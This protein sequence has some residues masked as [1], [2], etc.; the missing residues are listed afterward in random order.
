MRSGSQHSRSAGALCINAG[1]ACRARF[2]TRQERP[3][4]RS[5][6]HGAFD[7]V[8]SSLPTPDGACWLFF[9]SCHVRSGTGARQVMAAN[10][11]ADRLRAAGCLTHRKT[12]LTLTVC[13]CCCSSCLPHR[14][15]RR[16]CREHVNGMRICRRGKLLQSVINAG[17][18]A[19]AFD[20]G[21]SMI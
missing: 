19:H 6:T 16:W 18:P 12:G 20:V 8:P 7:A 15:G 1:C 21:P 9:G 17:L 3:V 11:A 4:C 13:R 2:S 14:A 10:D 5:S